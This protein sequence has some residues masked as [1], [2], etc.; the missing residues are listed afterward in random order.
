MREHDRPHAA[1]TAELL[2]RRLREATDEFLRHEGK[3][4]DAPVASPP[5]APVK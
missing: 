3:D 2:T 4:H 5:I 1:A